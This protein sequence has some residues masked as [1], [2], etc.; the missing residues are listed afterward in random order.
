MLVQA[1]AFALTCALDRLLL[2]P[3]WGGA[4]IHKLMFVQG[5]IAA[6]LSYAAGLERWWWPIQFFFPV[7]IVVMQKVNLPSGVYLF[8]FLVCLAVYWTTFQTRV[9]FFPTRPSTWN[10]VLPLLPEGRGLRFID[11]GSGFGGLVL[12]VA[13]CR[14]DCSV[15]GIEIAPLPW[16]VSAIRAVF[17]RADAR[18]IRGD[19]SALDLSKFDV[20]FAYL[21]P[22]AMPS[23]W[24]KARA[25]MRPGSLFLS[26]EFLVPGH[27]PTIVS[28]PDAN[29]ASLYGW[30]M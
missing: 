5:G 28:L 2:Q 29:R 6:L 8:A 1:I 4:E 10:A 16:I 26:Y 30:S 7:A 19:Y 13:K 9:P 18:F 12:H 27:E 25:E 3:L 24:E 14:P 22:A 11:L 23:L 21:S 20:V 15:M 17:C